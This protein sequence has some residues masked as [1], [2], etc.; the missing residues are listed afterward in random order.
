[1]TMQAA[2]WVTANELLKMGDIGRCELIH[3]EL[4]MMSPAGAEHGVVALR[5]GAAL[6]QFVDK[7]ELGAV[8]GAE[9]GFKIDVNPDTVRAPDASFVRKS[10]LGTRITKK[11]FDGPP[12]LAVEVVSPDDSRREVNDKANMWLARGAL[13]VWIADPKTMTVSILRVGQKPQVLGRGKTI[14]DEPLLPGFELSVDSIFK[15]P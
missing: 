11:F 10:R 9:T 13:T 6:V 7:N 2:K 5:I 8:F 4:I 12:D 3:G 14:R 1:M 15:M